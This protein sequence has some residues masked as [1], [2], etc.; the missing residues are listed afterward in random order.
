MEKKIKARSDF[1][2]SMKNNPIKL[3][4]AIKEH[5]IYYHK[6]RYNMSVIFD[7]MRTLLGTKQKKTKASK[8]IQNSSK[9]WLLIFV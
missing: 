5:S 3:L 4:K 1:K 2:S 8:T 6:N 9:S 7:S